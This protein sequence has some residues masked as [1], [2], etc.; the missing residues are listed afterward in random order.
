MDKKIIHPDLRDPM[1]TYSGVPQQ[2]LTTE[3]SGRCSHPMCDYSYLSIKAHHIIHHARG[4]LTVRPN[5]LMLCSKCHQLLHDGFIPQRL[6]FLIKYWVASGREVPLEVQE[7]SA[8]E[9]VSQAENIKDDKKLSPNEKFTEL[10]DV[11]IKANFLPSRNT[12]YYVFINTI[13]AKV[14]ILND[15]VSPLR[16]ELSAML[17]SMDYRRKWAQILAA[18]GSRYAREINHHWLNLY[19]IHSR[20]VGFNARNSFKGAVREFKE[21]LNALDGIPI[22]KRYQN[23][24]QQVRSRLLREMAVCRAKEK[25]KSRKAGREIL[26]SLDMAEAVG[27]SHNIDDALVRCVEGFIYLDEFPKAELYLSRLYENWTRL[28]D[29]LKAITMKMDAK[30]SLAPEKISHAEGLIEKGL[31]WSLK[32]K[33]HHQVYHFSRLNWNIKLKFEDKRQIFICSCHYLT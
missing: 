12:R 27:N 8:D 25:P 18:N 9:L 10:N 16:S 23:E 7:V 2:E 26:T 15:G 31:K 13:A 1:R 11:L 6:A 5:G 30:L 29:H 33:F 32:H 3:C 21:A 24:A 14:S 20:A 28:D 22:S 17:V 4:G 19:F